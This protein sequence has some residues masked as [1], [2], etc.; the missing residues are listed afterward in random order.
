MA[1]NTKLLKCKM[2]LN[3]DTTVT[4]A[5]YLGLNRVNVSAK[6]N[7]KREFKQSEIA[8][9]ISKYKLTYDE[10]NEIFFKEVV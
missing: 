4:L 5:S 8:K 9:I 10:M 6:I 7:G 3:N 2:I 1:T